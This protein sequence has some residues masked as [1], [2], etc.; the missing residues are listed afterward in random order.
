MSCGLRDIAF[1][2]VSKAFSASRLV[3]PPIL[4]DVSFLVYSPQGV[5]QQYLDNRNLQLEHKIGAVVLPARLLRV[6]RREVKQVYN[7]HKPK[8]R[9]LPPPEPFEPGQRFEDFVQMVDPL[10]S[11]PL[12]AQ[13]G[14]PRVA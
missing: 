3:F 14:L 1:L 5:R 10:V 13:E 6:N 12:P 7:K 4:P 2:L 9:N 8:K 11:P